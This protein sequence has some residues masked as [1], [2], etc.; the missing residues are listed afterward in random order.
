M[1]SACY[2]ADREGPEELP[3]GNSLESGE[4][5]SALRAAVRRVD[6]SEQGQYMSVFG[7]QEALE[8]FSWVESLSVWKGEGRQRMSNGRSPL[9]F[10]CW[11]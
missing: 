4:G 7:R 8:E 5:L 6:A 10:A 2:R 3:R 9:I 1:V 11:R